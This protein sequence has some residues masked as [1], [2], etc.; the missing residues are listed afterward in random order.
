M[1][2][3]VSETAPFCRFEDGKTDGAVNGNVFGTYLHGLFDT[4]ELTAR[5]ADWLAVRKGI[6]V[7][8][9]KPVPRVLYR[10]RQYDLLAEAVRKS[11]DMERIYRAMEE[12][13]DA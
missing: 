4:G 3:T 1:G 2:E 5:L 13:E 7:E 12:Y 6:T 9:Y 11:L 10:Q 8:P